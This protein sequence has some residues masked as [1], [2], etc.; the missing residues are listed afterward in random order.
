M[1]ATN[2]PAV[3]QLNAD[4]QG[5]TSNAV[6]LP[7]EAGLTGTEFFTNMVSTEAGGLGH[8]FNHNVTHAVAVPLEQ[9]TDSVRTSLGGFIR[10]TRS[11]VSE[12]PLITDGDYTAGTPE[13]PVLPKFIDTLQQQV[14]KLRS[15]LGI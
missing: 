8:L 12:H 10:A 1:S 7:T 4:A 3:N 2:L 9:A 14:N 13:T 6:K 15:Y 11:F 5:L